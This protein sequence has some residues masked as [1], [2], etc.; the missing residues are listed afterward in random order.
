M[1]FQRHQTKALADRVQPFLDLIQEMFETMEQAVH[2]TFDSNTPATASQ[3][4]PSTPNNHQFSQSPRPSSPATALTS[5]SSSDI[6]SEHQQTR[7]LLKGMQSNCVNK[8]VKL[9]VPLI[10]NVL[11]LQAKPQEKAHE[12]AKAQGKIFTGVSKEIRNRQRLATSS[13]LKSKL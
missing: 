7:M 3:G 4:V 9:F 12:E 5:G 8:N 11:L 6:G 10:K 1:D 2:D 13:Q